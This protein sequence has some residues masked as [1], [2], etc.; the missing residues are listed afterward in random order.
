MEHLFIYSTNQVLF[1]PL[2]V[3]CQIGSYEWHVPYN[4]L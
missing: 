1:L 2:E 4:Q 3:G